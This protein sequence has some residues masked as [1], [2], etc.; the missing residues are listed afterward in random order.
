MRIR[1]ARKVLMCAMGLGPA[2]R[3]VPR[4]DVLARAWRRF[5]RWDRLDPHYPRFLAQ[6]VAIGHSIKAHGAAAFLGG[7]P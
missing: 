3:R 4:A 7:I 2:K 5:H 6:R 1:V